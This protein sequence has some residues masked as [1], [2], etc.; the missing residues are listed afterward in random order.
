M[1]ASVFKYSHPGLQYTKVFS[2][3]ASQ[4][5]FTSHSDALSKNPSDPT[6]PLFSILDQLEGFRN[7][8]GRFRLKLCWPE[9]DWGQGGC[10]CNEWLQT[11]NPVNSTDITGFQVT[12]DCP[13][14]NNLGTKIQIFL[15]YSL[16]LPPRA[17]PWPSPKRV[18]HPGT[19]RGW[20]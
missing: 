13:A 5:L 18:C 11:S 2:H 8:E 10:H 16:F 9:L 1:C 14:S 15:L 4:G 7:Q 12:T 19:G 6:A 3:D 20:G 17:S